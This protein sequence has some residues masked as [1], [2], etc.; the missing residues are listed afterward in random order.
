MNPLNYITCPYERRVAQ[1]GYTNYREDERW[2]SK[3]N[4]GLFFLLLRL[5]TTTYK[6]QNYT[7]S[8]LNGGREWGG[9]G[10]MAKK[11]VLRA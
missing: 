6:W 2:T 1:T 8:K 5:K 4:R 9:G 10:R 3:F 11:A 7:V